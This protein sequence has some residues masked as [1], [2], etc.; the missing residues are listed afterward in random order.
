MPRQSQGSFF[1]VK[2]YQDINVLDM[3]VLVMTH[4]Y[5]KECCNDSFTDKLH[6]KET[7]AILQMAMASISTTTKAEPQ[8]EDIFPLN[9]IV[10]QGVAVLQPLAAIGESLL[11]WGNAVHL[12]DLHLDIVDGI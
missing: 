3:T 7:S 4:H 8:M 5:C 9:V 6:W 2:K 11:Y 12:V 1:L 10:R